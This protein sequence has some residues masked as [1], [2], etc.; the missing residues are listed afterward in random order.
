LNIAKGN[1]AQAQQNLAQSKTNS[2]VLAQILNKDYANAQ[3]T[4]AAIKT[5]DA[6]TGY[7]KAILAARTNDVGAVK[8][9]LKVAVTSD[10]SLKARAAKDLEFAKYKET[11]ADLVK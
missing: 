8:S 1:Y 3:K 9:N 6:I 4:L 10:P 7:L 5:P 11:I 2:A